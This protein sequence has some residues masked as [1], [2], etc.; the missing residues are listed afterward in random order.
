[1]ACGEGGERAVVEKVVV[2]MRQCLGHV[3]PSVASTFK[4]RMQESSQLASRSSFEPAL[5]R[6]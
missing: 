2:G 4:Q 5:K 3:C 1:M 6:T